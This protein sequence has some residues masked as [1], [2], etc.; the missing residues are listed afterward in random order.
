MVYG[1]PAKQMGWVT[2]EGNK[3]PLPLSGNGKYKCQIFKD[4]YYL[5]NDKL[6]IE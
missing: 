6:I 4:V 5:E 1:N 3:I 2:K